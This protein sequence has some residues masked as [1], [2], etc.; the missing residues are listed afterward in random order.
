ML[1]NELINLLVPVVGRVA[2]RHKLLSTDVFRGF[3][4]IDEVAE[5][6]NMKFDIVLIVKRS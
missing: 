1:T 6:G 2:V 3:H 4:V 5:S